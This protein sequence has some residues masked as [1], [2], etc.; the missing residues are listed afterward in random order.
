MNKSTKKCINMFNNLSCHPKI[1]K[2]NT[3]HLHIN[4]HKLTIK[5]PPLIVSHSKVYS[6]RIKKCVVYVSLTE[7]DFKDAMITLMNNISTLDYD[8]MEG[9]RFNSSVQ[10]DKYLRLLWPLDSEYP[11]KGQYIQ[12]DIS[13]D[14]V[15]QTYK[16]FGVLIRVNSYTILN[17]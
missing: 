4:E 1:N 6:S 10:D 8:F 5:T 12:V 2:K 3:Y 17:K 14:T 7:G 11:K 13:P 15:W 9:K 16:E